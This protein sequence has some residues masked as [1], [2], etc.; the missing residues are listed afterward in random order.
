MRRVSVHEHLV[1][2]G[3]IQSEQILSRFAADYRAFY[4]ELNEGVVSEQWKAETQ[5][6]GKTLKN[7][8]RELN[9]L[10]NIASREAFTLYESYGLPYEIIKEVGVLAQSP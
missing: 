7:G 10:A 8:M 2:E 9:K 5:K 1:G 3:G 4:P 6:F